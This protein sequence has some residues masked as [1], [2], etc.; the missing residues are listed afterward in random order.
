MITLCKILSG[1]IMAVAACVAAVNLLDFLRFL[2]S[3]VDGAAAV[4]TSSGSAVAQ[5]VV[6]LLLA[7]IVFLLADSETLFPTP[8]KEP[9][10]EGSAM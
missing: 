4:A 10:N 1:I 7:A 3:P 9:D 6:I 8:A 5:A 2:G